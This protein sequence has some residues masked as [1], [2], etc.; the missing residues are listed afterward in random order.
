M[1]SNLQKLNFTSLIKWL[2]HPDTLKLLG[3]GSASVGIGYYIVK[4]VT[5]VNLGLDE[6][7]L[8][9]E[10]ENSSDLQKSE[11]LIQILER[12]ESSTNTNETFHEN[13]KTS[14]LFLTIKLIVSEDLVLGSNASKV[15]HYLI[16]NL[17][18]SSKFIELD[19]IEM[20]ILAIQM[21]DPENIQFETS[22]LL[23]HLKL[24]YKI[25]KLSKEQAVDLLEKTRGI[26]M[27]GTLLTINETPEEIKNFV[28]K[29]LTWACEYS[30]TIPN[31]LS[32]IEVLPD[33]VNML[34]NSNQEIVKYSSSLICDCV[35]IPEICL[36]LEE[37]G[38]IPKLVKIINDVTDEEIL[39]NSC[40]AMTKLMFDRQMSDV[41]CVEYEIIPVIREKFLKK[42]SDNLIFCGLKFIEF[43]ANS[44]YQNKI[45]IRESE[46]FN[47]LK[48]LLIKQKVL[49][50]QMLQQLI[51]TINELTVQ[52]RK[53]GNVK[54]FMNLYMLPLLVNLFRISK[55]PK[56]IS[57]LIVI[58][59][60]CAC[61]YEEYRIR[62]LESSIIP[63]LIQ[64]LKSTRDTIVERNIIFTFANL[65]QSTKVQK[66][67]MDHDGIQG[68]VACL[69][70][71]DLQTQYGSI[72]GLKNIFFFG[73]KDK[74]QWFEIMNY[75]VSLNVINHFMELL[76]KEETHLREPIIEIL[77]RISE[78]PA[79][80]QEF[81][82]NI[83]NNRFF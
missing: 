3:I 15:A 39:C 55:D 65:A 43:A 45:L 23:D 10:L 58:F 83:P 41:I 36:D 42:K 22:A 81:G 66:E 40:L 46:I 82:K 4:Q 48:D 12:F 25:I 26:S 80:Y 78:H 20:L 64:L 59:G 53:T 32:K 8:L 44:S 29:C 2:F 63:Q 60:N 18:Y 77:K 5:S 70:S 49:G 7:E 9:K 35:E 67:L 71:P 62:L 30:S 31:L 73:P 13:F 57:D 61:S 76:K 47:I 72:V 37:Y 75:L 16:S 79:V 21:N 38:I 74:I 11:T 19:G 1:F 50:R 33:V 52:S 6:P 24:L 28:L 56:I 17:V 34:S 14:A 27:L 51:S 69:Y 68:M 54:H